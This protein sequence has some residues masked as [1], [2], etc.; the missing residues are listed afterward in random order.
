VRRAAAERGDRST[1]L[2][3]CLELGQG[4]LRTSLGESFAPR[5]GEVDLDG[6]EEAY[7]RAAELAE[8]L[9]EEASLAAALRELG[10]I[11]LGR[12]R[13]WFVER[14][15]AGGH[16]ELLAR[17]AGGEPLHA[18]LPTLP[19]A[20]TFARAQELLE[21][22]LEVYERVGDRR[23]AMSSVIAL[24][25][26]SWAP[27]IHLGAGAGRHIEEIR[28]LTSRMT[29]MARESERA[30]AEAHML[31]G[32]HLFAWA[33]AVPDLAVSRGAEAYRQARAIGDQGLEFLSAGG[34]ALAHL[35]L[36]D[37]EEAG[38]WLD[39]AAAAAAASP[40]PFRARQLE[41]WRGLLAAAAGDAPG[42]RGHLERAVQMA[43]EG[44]RAAAR[45]EALAHLALSASLLGSEQGDQDLLRLA[46]DAAGEAR[47][48]MKLLPGHPPW[49][50]RADAALAR[51]A[52][53]RGDV[54]AGVK[55]ARSALSALTAALREDAHL[56]ILIPVAEALAAGGADDER[57]ATQT[58]LR[59]TLA[60]IAQ[61]TLDE[62]VRVRWLR[63][64]LG[65]AV[66]RLAGPLDGVAIEPVG[67]PASPLDRSDTELLGLLLEGLTNREMAE[68]L[69]ADVATVSR[70]L[71]ELLARIGASSRAEATAFAFR[72]RVV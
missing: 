8:Q 37:L 9:G 56:E 53:A 57:R 72:E 11:G 51:V 36:G 34:T 16:L 40:T 45:C 6:A 52:L 49:G 21:R 1:E 19:V 5:A 62:E 63:S 48:L 4:L 33:K 25:Y 41:T 61:R 69:N 14:V 31:Y 23:G 42:M 35:D 29:T 59:I 46:E 64:P 15:L 18:I 13:A 55:A 27:D 47:D 66:T 39:R 38:R 10:V 12:V 50:A 71:A 24:A 44:G 28:R 17:V 32:T 60:L 58:L 7:G 65:R 67:G 54:E 22:A 2:A 68:R 70:R 26:A 3:A 43:T 20:P 30:Q